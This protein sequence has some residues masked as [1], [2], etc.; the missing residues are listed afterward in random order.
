MALR[1]TYRELKK[2][3][4]PHVDHL[5]RGIFHFFLW[6]MGYYKRASYGCAYLEGFCISQ[7]RSRG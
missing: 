5:K 6:Q 2:Y 4:N 7:S 3:K 1:G